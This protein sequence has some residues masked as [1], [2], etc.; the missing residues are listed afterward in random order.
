MLFSL[1][2]PATPRHLP[3]TPLYLYLCAH[4]LAF[5]VIYLSRASLSVQCLHLP[6]L[7]GLVSRLRAPARLCYLC[8][9][10]IRVHSLRVCRAIFLQTFKYCTFMD[11]LEYT[12]PSSIFYSLRSTFYCRLRSYGI[13][14]LVQ[15]RLTAHVHTPNNKWCS[16]YPDT[17][18]RLDARYPP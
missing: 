11:V 1:C 15:R 9:L 4:M 14:F 6:T 2:P 16:M 10:G 7:D 12:H 13:E 8:I 5:P 17:M 18:R 3:R